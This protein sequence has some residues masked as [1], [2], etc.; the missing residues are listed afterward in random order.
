MSELVEYETEAHDCGCSDG[1]VDNNPTIPVE[2][3]HPVTTVATVAQHITCQTIVIASGDT[4]GGVWAL[5]PLDPLRVRAVILSVDQD[6]VICHTRPQAQASGNTGSSVPNP[7]GAYLPKT[8]M[9][10]L[11]GTQEMWVAATSATPT[12]VSI[13]V[14]R[15]SP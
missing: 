8:T 15:R 6:V 5:L 7:S 2:I 10:T 9:L 1:T 4:Q 11:N 14:E 12:R 13:T 3:T